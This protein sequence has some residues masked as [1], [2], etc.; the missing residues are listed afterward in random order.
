MKFNT[1]KNL[2]FVLRLLIGGSPSKFFHLKEFGEKLEKKGHKCKLVT[3]TDIFS[4][5]PSR[6]LKDWFDNK[7]KFKK[8]VSEFSPDAIFVDRQTNFGK[9]A[10]EEKIP[11]FVHL[12]GDYWA[13][14][15]MAKETLY[16]YPPKRSVIWFKERIA[17]ICFQG[18]SAI[19]PICEHLCKSVEQHYPKKSVHVMYQGI[20]SANWFPEETMELKHPCVGLLQNATIWEKAKEMLTI[21]KVLKK[22]PDVT[23]YWAGD[24][25]YRDKILPELNKFDNFKWIGSLEYPK[26]V[27]KFLNSVD[28]YA[29]ISGIDMSPLTLQ[30]AQLMRKPVIATN[31][32]GIPELMENNK[33]G[34]LVKKGNADNLHEKIEKLINDKDLQI[35]FGNTGREFIENNFSWDVIVDGFLENVKTKIN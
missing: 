19:F 28:I 3:D 16:R 15:K 1:W 29:L 8:I 35:N 25:V 11:L 22:M 5:F 4:G 34:F 18:A 24:G 23:F 12:R 26:N 2:F 7:T 32:G 20:N 17:H 6:H 21:T 31:V 33:T 9:A 13:E 14:S 10:I 27:R 30:E